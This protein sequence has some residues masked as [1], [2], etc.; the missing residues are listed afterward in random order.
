MSSYKRDDKVFKA[1][2][3][4]KAME[5]R[6]AELVVRLEKILRELREESKCESN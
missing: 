4:A 3:V 2:L 6:R 1:K 5:I